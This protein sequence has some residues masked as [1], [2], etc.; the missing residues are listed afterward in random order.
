MIEAKNITSTFKF[1]EA[2]TAGN[3]AKDKFIAFYFS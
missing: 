1:L 2:V 3:K